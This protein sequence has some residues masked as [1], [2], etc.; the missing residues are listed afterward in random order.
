MAGTEA[1]T[2]QKEKSYDIAK[3]I[4]A[5]KTEIKE[6]IDSEKTLSASTLDTW[7]TA[8]IMLHILDCNENMPENDVFK[9]ENAKP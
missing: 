4:K 2:F 5:N 8:K 1:V 6:S 9:S 7:A 3:H